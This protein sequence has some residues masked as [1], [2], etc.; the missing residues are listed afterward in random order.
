MVKK[1]NNTFKILAAG[2]AIYF[3]FFRGK[4]NST[5]MD[6]LNFGESSYT[7]ERRNNISILNQELKNCGFTNR[8][9]RVAI[10][11]VIGKESNYIPKF[12]TCYNNTS[13]ARIRQFFS[14]TRSLSDI[15]L[16]LLKA[17]CRNFFNFVYDN[18]Y[19]NGSGDG[20]KYRG[21]G[22]NGLTFRGSY[23]SI[24]EQIGVNLEQQ[25]E[26]NNT[27]TVAAKSLC[28]FMKNRATS[29]AGR[30]LLQR[31]GFNSYNDINNLDFAVRFFANCNAGLGNGFNSGVV[32]YAYEKSKPYIE[33]VYSLTL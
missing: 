5:N 28:A 13:N 25:P 27:P 4:K 3:L 32:N 31:Y 11:A 22:Y 17:D 23:R 18:K 30:N 14:R 29:A 9:T 19:G 8:L 12:E 21:T 20:Y 7:G 26:L 10:L 6:N 24:G 33:K 2:A 16:N 1:R 15:Q